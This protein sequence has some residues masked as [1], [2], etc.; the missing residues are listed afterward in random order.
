MEVVTATPTQA[1]IYS[2]LETKL[3]PFILIADTRGLAGIV[4]PGCDS[5]RF[6]AV[7]RADEDHSLLGTAARQITEYLQGKRTHFTLPLSLSGTRFQRTVW[8]IIAA[9]PYGA[10][11]TYGQ[12]ARELGSPN[13]ARAVGGAARAN[14]LPLI[15][16]CHRVVGANGR[17]TG[18]SGGLALKKNFLGLEGWTL[19]QKT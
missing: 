4:L 19:C 7:P 14:P 8:D 3:G 12:I 11:R 5:G 10:T 6:P 16:P 13:K 15:I 17:L 18:F 9:I 1:M 2:I